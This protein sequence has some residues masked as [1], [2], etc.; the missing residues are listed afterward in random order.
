MACKACWQAWEVSERWF[1]WYIVCTMV[2][3]HW[4]LLSAP[5][6]HDAEKSTLTHSVC[7]LQDKHTSTLVM[8]NLQTTGDMCLGAFMAGIVVTLAHLSGRAYTEFLCI[9]TAIGLIPF[10]TTRARY[11]KSMLQALHCLACTGHLLY[12]SNQNK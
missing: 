1:V 3:F 9:F 7:A 2:H 12:T 11:L 10:A 4:L 5:T 8:S 6:C